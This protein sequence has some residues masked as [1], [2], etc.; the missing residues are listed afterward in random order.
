MSRYVQ[1]SQSTMVNIELPPT[2]AW[3]DSWLGNFAGGRD[4]APIIGATNAIPRGALELLFRRDLFRGYEL[5]GTDYYVRSAENI[6]PLYNRIHRL[7]V[8]PLTGDEGARQRWIW[9]VLGF[10]GIPVRAITD[11]DAQAVQ[12]FELPYRKNQLIEAT[13]SPAELR[14]AEME[15]QLKSDRSQESAAQV[16][17]RFLALAREGYGG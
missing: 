9:S 2:A 8:Q 17:E 3:R 6:F 1:A 7:G 13:S 10:T 4:P 15:K 16:R 12:Q 5:E 14:L 11:K